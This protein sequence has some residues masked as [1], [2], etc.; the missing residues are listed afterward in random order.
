MKHADSLRARI[1]RFYQDNPSEWLS[2]DDMAVKF[3]CTHDQAKMACH[4]LARNGRCAL[5]SM[6]IVRLQVCKPQGGNAV[7]FNAASR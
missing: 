1:K 4:G 2:F 3:G 6:H 7:H 5:E